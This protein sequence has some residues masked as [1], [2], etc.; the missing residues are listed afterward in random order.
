MNKKQIII[1]VL[2]ITAFLGITSFLF[3][4]NKEKQERY[5]YLFTGDTEIVRWY[6]NNDT[7][8]I[9]NT[10][11]KMSDS[12]DVYSNGKYFGNYNLMY[13]EGW[14]YF[15]KSNKN[16]EIDGIKF[17]VNTNFDFTSYEY[18]VT[19]KNDD[20]MV[21]KISDKLNINYLD[22]DY[23]LKI[24]NVTD[25][26]KMENIYFLH[27][28]NKDDEYVK[29]GPIYTVAAVIKNKEITILKSL[30]FTNSEV[31]SC[32]L[33][34]EGVFTF[35]NNNNKILLSCAHFDQIPSDYYLYEE[36]L[37]NYELVVD[38]VGGA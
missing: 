30:S 19:Y 16:I 32:N 2:L 26:K 23:N 34:L 24:F 25:N 10:N 1:L 6:Y 12:F 21:K 17:M 4:K 9:V 15:N 29:L 35:E 20:D 3:I 22:Y 14:Y 36:K 28:Y 5:L 31:N 13:N 11:E 7:W 37:F 38:S 33:T 18:N 8:Y 27:F